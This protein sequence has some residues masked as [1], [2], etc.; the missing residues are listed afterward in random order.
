MTRTRSAAAGLAAALF[1]TGASGLVY[2]V[3][4]S[5]YLGLLLGSSA[6]AIVVVLAAFM[7]GLAIGSW[8]FG[9]LADRPIQ[10]LALY[11]WLELSIGLYC[12]LYP[13]LQAALSGPYLRL[14]SPLFL[15]HPAA[16]TAARLLFAALLLLPP[17]IL[18]GGTLP[19]ASRFLLGLMPGVRRAVGRLYFVNSAGAVCGT[20]LAGFWLIP[21]L[22]LDLSMSVAAAVNVG[23]GLAALA[24]RR[25]FAEDAGAVPASDPAEQPLSARTA[26]LATSAVAVSGFA[27]LALE[28]AWT[29]L[30]ALSM[31][32]STYAFTTMLATFILG[33]ALGSRLIASRRFSG[34]DPVLLLAGCLVAVAV[35]LALSMSFGERLPFAFLAVREIIRASPRGYV[36]YQV[37]S[38]L[39]C[40]AVM[41]VPTTAMGATLPL[42]SRIAARSAS[43]LGSRIGLTY[44]ANTFGTLLGALLAG[45]VFLPRF[46]LQGTMRLIVVLYVVAGAVALLGSEHLR[47]R[48]ATAIAAAAVAAAA[49]TLAAPAWR[50][51]LVA[52]GAFRARAVDPEYAE[53]ERHA[54]QA[55][56]LVFNADGPHA[57]V[58]VVE[59]EG[60]RTL[61]VNGKADAS[62]G[63]DMR[64]QILAGHLPALLSPRPAQRALVIGVGSGTSVGMMAMHPGIAVDAVEIEPQVVRAAHDWFKDW[65]GGALDRPNVHVHVEDA[66]TFL[67]LSREPYDLIASE[68]SNPW[69]AGIGGLFTEDF[70]QLAR[71]RLRP[72]GLMAQ[73]FHT[74][75]MG[76]DNA[77]LVLRTFRK[78]FPH[79]TVWQTLGYDL[80]LI[81][82]DRPLRLDAAELEKRMSVPEVRES[83]ARLAIQDPPTL[84]S[85]QM[86]SES[87]AAL[88][89]GEGPLNSDQ[90][91]ALEFS[92]PRDFFLS[93]SSHIFSNLD[94]R[95]Q[96][97]NK[98]LLLGQYLAARPLDR[99][100]AM[101]MAEALAWTQVLSE[102]LLRAA[103]AMDRGDPRAAMAL[104]RLLL[105]QRQPLEARAVLAGAPERAD[106]G[107]LRFRLELEL[108]ACG[109]MRS[110]FVPR[111]DCDG[112]IS[113]ARRLL[114]LPDVPPADRRGDLANLAK[115]QLWAG[116]AAD[117]AATYE[118][119]L[120]DETAAPKQR[121]GWLA[122][123]AAAL[124]AAGDA[125]RAESRAREALALEPR[126]ETAKRLL[127]ELGDR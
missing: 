127:A 97:G 22:G 82:S 18:M 38:F 89:A 24:L 32:G 110:A 123:E 44:A 92:A 29:R 98:K 20:L 7:G 106:A 71:T 54:M 55:D 8:G 75:E 42:A 49:W 19:A 84:L 35:T 21:S 116:R 87:S 95:A 23:V 37:A 64:T 100:R 50:P 93:S 16:F 57:T 99:A 9:R 39:L 103:H 47:R 117:A 28:V 12:G 79:T 11:G 90:F 25:H 34:R 85:Y 13:H 48:S 121:A 91:P 40:L 62:T 109:A 104:A 107:M 46:G 1:L 60:R 115:A 96:L 111:A 2:Q 81:G 17:T 4:W 112:A 124:M 59:G 77:Q 108:V 78:V 119:V 66:K 26:A 120:K 70:F 15:A 53:F 31:G 74:Y 76:D 105:Q 94:E 86:L 63:P 51:Q 113:L 114:A 41:I 88:A 125:Q 10:R 27:A 67:L 61:R 56:K 101:A 58:T 52:S 122:A 102:P 33:V 69:L 45:L 30:L 6:V 3:L 68:P 5:R 80:L 73:W 118:K 126:Q 83:L 36:L 65:N 43:A 14:V 72:G